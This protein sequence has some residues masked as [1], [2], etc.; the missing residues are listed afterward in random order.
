TDMGKA[1]STSSSSLGTAYH[2]LGVAS[3]H[4]QL[5][6]GILCM[7]AAVMANILYVN[8]DACSHKGVRM[9]DRLAPFLGPNTTDAV[10]AP[11]TSVTSLPLGFAMLTR[12]SVRAKNT[13]NIM[14]ATS[15]CRRRWTFLLS[16]QVR[17]CLGWTVKCIG[18]H[19]F[20]LKEVPSN[21][22]LITVIFS[23]NGLLLSPPPSFL[24][25]FGPQMGGQAYY[26]DLLFGS[27][28]IDFAGSGVVHMAVSLR[29]HSASLV[30]LGT[31]LL[32]FGWYGFN[33]GSF[34]KILVTYNGESGG[35][36]VNGRRGPY[37]SDHHVNG[38][39][40]ALTTL[41]GKRILSGHWNV[42]DVCNG[43]PRGGFAAITAGCS[44][45]TSVGR[46][47]L[48]LRGCVSFNRL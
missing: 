24:I 45:V 5:A 27:G 2:T 43:L 4:L 34:N 37:R 41:F 19:F 30:V 38:C 3:P 29:G 35:I 1:S 32:W 20:G 40:A 26:S 10:A 16:V 28:V 18:R 6:P 21:S 46:N 33:P 8:G 17:F 15:R 39:T 14:L 48:R 36:M 25:G 42:T 12:S 9:A 23:I 13:M 22:F 31:F 7:Q 44:V 11:L 47:H